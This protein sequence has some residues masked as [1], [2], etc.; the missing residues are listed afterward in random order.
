MNIASADATGLDRAVQWVKDLT[1][2]VE[3]GELFDGE[4]TRVENFGAFVRVLPGQEGLVHVSQLSNKRID[5]VRKVVKIGDK[6]KVMVTEIDEKG[7]IN[8]SRTLAIAKIAE[9][10]KEQK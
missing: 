7:R 4:V 10:K 5:D 8:L 6:M 9:Q 1:R 2:K 3:P